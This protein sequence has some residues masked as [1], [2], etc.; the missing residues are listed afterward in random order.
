MATAYASGGVVVVGLGAD[1]WAGLGDEARHALREAGTV[2]GSPRQ[3]DLL[4]V[5]LGA[6]RVAW[7]SP[8]RGA[9]RALVDE[10]ASTG[11]AVLA[12]GDPMMYGL[13]RTLVDEPDVGREAT[14][15]FIAE[16]QAGFKLPKSR[17]N[18]QFRFVRE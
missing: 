7:R 12:S 6:A 11:V 9:V 15:D 13:G 1:G 10:Y 8:H 17:A 16:S 14:G 2:I 18:A 4:P 5:W 3:L